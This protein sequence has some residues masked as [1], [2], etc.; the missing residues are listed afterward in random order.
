MVASDG[1]IGG[2]HPRGAGT[3]PKVLGRFV[4][5]QHWLTLEEAIRKMAALPA[6][7]LGLA[8][9][10]VIRIG[11]KADLVIFNP[12]TVID[13]STFKEPQ[14]LSEGILRVFVNG[15]PVWEN[16]KPTARLPGSVLRKTAGGRK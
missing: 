14:L 13:R 7:R 16:G 8:E 10:G 4:R 11:A 9:R 1:G 15:E 6:R 3:F 5:E 2:R 12:K